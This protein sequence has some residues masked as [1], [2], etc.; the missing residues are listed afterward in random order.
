MPLFASPIIG[1]FLQ[2]PVREVRKPPA[3]P[4]RPFSQ[5]S[6]FVPATVGGAPLSQKELD[7]RPVNP[8]IMLAKASGNL[9]GGSTPQGGPAGQTTA[10]DLAATEQ[11]LIAFLRSKRGGNYKNAGIILSSSAVVAALAWTSTGHVSWFLLTSSLAFP[12]LGATALAIG[13]LAYIV[14]KGVATRSLKTAFT[15]L[16]KQVRQSD[17]NNLAAVLYGRKQVDIKRTL[18]LFKGEQKAQ[19]ETL[20]RAVQSTKTA[21]TSSAPFSQLQAWLTGGANLVADMGQKF[22]AQTQ[23]LETAH[24]TIADQTKT[25]E[26]LR[27]E[28][29]A[30]TAQ[31]VGGISSLVLGRYFRVREVG[32]GGMAM[33]VLV[34]D[35][36]AKEL[37]VLKVPLFEQLQNPAALRRFAEREADIMLE[38]DHP[39]VV[40][41]YA[42]DYLTPATY[43]ELTSI[44]L[45]GRALEAQ[46]IPYI[47]MEFIESKTLADHFLLNKRRGYKSGF[48]SS[49]S[50]KIAV[51]IARV[52]RYV[53][54]KNII[55]RD[56]KPDNLFLVPDQDGQETVKIADF[57]IA[58]FLNVEDGL[59]KDGM[60]FGTP[61]Y[62]S[63]EQWRGEEEKID[64]KVDQYAL[65]VILYEMLAATVPYGHLK[66]SHPS[67]QYEYI[68]N[69]L[70]SP[71]PDIRK[72]ISAPDP[73]VNVLNR[74]LAKRPE[75]RFQNWDE[76]IESLTLVLQAI[77]N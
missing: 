30:Q 15:N 4:T 76:C 69:V 54:A 12:V 67:A 58:K 35:V 42:L 24:K 70:N 74:M 38:L 14:V 21:E 31:M 10:P 22:T 57:G 53:H 19:L 18:N 43:E 61:A 9:G 71:L 65:G 2:R 6:P 34:F 77:E 39:Q 3:K 60:I 72:H 46:R 64:W 23:D 48:R 1:K 51:D 20:I 5:F 63:P 32:A 17:L 37:R 25:I 29:T 66:S 8:N 49:Y 36:A 75:Q 73:L 16:G 11:N 50:L 68:Q 56:L 33:A 59:T 55:H 52:L 41:F 13:T 26:R 40:R 27:E 47:V 28:L 45:K 7:I 62:I 44:P